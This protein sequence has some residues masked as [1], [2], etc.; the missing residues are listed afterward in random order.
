MRPLHEAM[1][2]AVKEERARLTTRRGLLTGAAKLSAGGMLALGAV[3]APGLG[4]LRTQTQ[5]EEFEDDIA[6]LNYALEAEEDE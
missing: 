5:E 4:R 3:G 6:V 1:L 2:D